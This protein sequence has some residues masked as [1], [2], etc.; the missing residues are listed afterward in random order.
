MA[1]LVFAELDDLFFF[2]P[3]VNT[4][5][6]ENQLGKRYFQ[7]NNFFFECR[8]ENFLSDIQYLIEPTKLNNIN[9]LS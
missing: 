2:C 6:A 5:S 8:I 3:T 9:P 1:E 7:R 4:N